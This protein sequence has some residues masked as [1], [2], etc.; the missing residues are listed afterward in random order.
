MRVILFASQ[1]VKHMIALNKTMAIGGWHLSIYAENSFNAELWQRFNEFLSQTNSKSDMHIWIRNCI[2]NKFASLETYTAAP[3]YER[4]YGVFTFDVYPQPD[5]YAW[6]IWIKPRRVFLA[7]S[8]EL[9][10]KYT[11]L[12]ADN[13]DTS[14][15]SAFDRLADIFSYSVL[16]LG[17]IVFH[18]VVMEYQGR[19]V[20]LSAPSG[21]GK[22][23]HSNL[24]RELGL[25]TIINGDR[26]L[27]R[28]VDGTWRVFGMPWC[29]SSGEFQ[30]RDVPILAIV[31]LEQH[32]E[33]ILSRLSPLNALT[34]MLPNVFAPTWE[35]TLYNKMLDRLDEI[36]PAVPVF[37]LRCRPDLDAVMTLK[38]VLD[39][40]LTGSDDI[41]PDAIC[42]NE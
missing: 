33:N 36:I 35:P 25:V 24:W 1:I 34:H 30:N 22:T 40:L 5:G 4:K 31:V 12:I 27:C 39:S 41:A 9:S 10:W 23:T 7:Y 3:I 17:G 37:H 38:P 16:S 13:T 28:Y 2:S 26:A 42:V 29:G 11:R 32:N 14:G 21:T 18:G 8:I 6:V 15:Q 19:G 20:I